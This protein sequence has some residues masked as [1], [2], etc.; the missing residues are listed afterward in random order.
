MICHQ[1]KEVMPIAI[2]VQ[3]FEVDGV[4]K[5]FHMNC[6]EPWYDKEIP[7]LR[8]THERTSFVT[9]EPYTPQPE[10]EVTLEWQNMPQG[11][12]HSLREFHGF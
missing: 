1:C 5:F 6:F 12:F 10:E 2:V 7:V 4:L 11:K 3:P 8:V 9:Q